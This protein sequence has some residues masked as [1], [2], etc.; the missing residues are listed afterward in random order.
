M[1]KVWMCAGWSPRRLRPAILTLN[2]KPG[3]CA[4]G[5]WMEPQT[6]VAWVK[7]K[8]SAAEALW[9]ETQPPHVDYAL[10]MEAEE[11]EAF[12]M[13]DYSQELLEAAGIRNDAGDY[14]KVG[15]S[16]SGK[17]GV[18]SYAGSAITSEADIGQT[19]QYDEDLPKLTVKSNPNVPSLW[20]LV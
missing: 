7:A 14:Y 18:K 10:V 16:P 6:A 20:L 3:Q 5:R 11:D 17:N 8:L 19:P 1:A 2:L 4:D 13:T 9:A 15:N 12:F